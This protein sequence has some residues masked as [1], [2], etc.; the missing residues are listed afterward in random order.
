MCAGWEGIARGRFSASALQAV[1]P[2]AGRRGRRQPQQNRHTCSSWSATAMKVLRAYSSRLATP[3]CSSQWRRG[4]ESGR[5]LALLLFRARPPAGT[6]AVQ[7]LARSQPH[8]SQVGCRPPHPPP[9]TL[10]Q[11]ASPR[12]HCPLHAPT[13][14]HPGRTTA[15]KRRLNIRGSA[16]SGMMRNSAPTL[17]PGAIA[18][19][20]KMICSGQG[21]SAGAVGQ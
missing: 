5:Q 19:L 15:V 20:L 17:I 18:P 13:Q 9:R 16:Q 1:G 14:H 8:V 3:P 10:D 12:M 21:E 2:A 11:G 4:A 6:P 7:R